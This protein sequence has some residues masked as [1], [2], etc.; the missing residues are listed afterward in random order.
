MRA[1]EVSPELEKALKDVPAREGNLAA[2]KRLHEEA[3]FDLMEAKRWLR[4]DARF[5]MVR[6]TTRRAS[7]PE[8]ELRAAGRVPHPQAEGMMWAALV[9]MLVGAGAPDATAP[10]RPRLIVLTDISSL[11]A[12]VAEPDDGQ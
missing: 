3:V 6:T 10:E 9:T 4:D 2:I 11:T 7:A 1:K 12:G 5:L 8:Q